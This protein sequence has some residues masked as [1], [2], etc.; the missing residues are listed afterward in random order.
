[1]KMPTIEVSVAALDSISAMGQRDKERIAELESALK[2]IHVWASTDECCPLPRDKSMKHIA[3]K[4]ISVLRVNTDSQSIIV[5][6]E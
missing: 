1:M 3:D 2:V 4:S 5:K 6:G